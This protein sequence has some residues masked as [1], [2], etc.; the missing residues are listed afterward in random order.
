MVSPR[1]W[2]LIL[3][4]LLVPQGVQAQ[5]D[6]FRGIEV[7]GGIA[8]W[9]GRQAPLF[10]PGF[11]GVVV[12]TAD[13]STTRKVLMEVLYGRFDPDEEGTA[14]TELGVSVGARQTLGDPWGTNPYLQ[15]RVGVHRIA[16]TGARSGYHQTGLLLGPEAGIETPLGE[17]V[18][19]MA[20]FEV[21]WLWYRD[22]AASGAT[23]EGTGG[24]AFRYGLRLGAA[25][26][27][28]R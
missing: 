2:S 18:H 24:Y 16:G 1:S 27:V 14:V 22:T 3:F 15:G 28:G 5:F 21:S 9:G 23:F 10:K 17:R 8:G 7:W 6:P 20:A 26:R 11:R 12:L 19:L 4:A 25:Y 13:A